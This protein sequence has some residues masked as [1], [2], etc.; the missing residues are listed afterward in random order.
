MINFILFHLSLVSSIKNEFHSVV[1]H[2]S[3]YEPKNLIK[4]LLLYVS[5][6][7][8]LTL[9]GPAEEQGS[10]LVLFC[11]VFPYALLLLEDISRNFHT[12]ILI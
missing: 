1:K 5:Q 10:C 3:I 6:V 8:Q 4:S 7:P 2:K 9:I 12:V 11:F